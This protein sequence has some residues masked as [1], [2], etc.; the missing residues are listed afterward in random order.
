MFVLSPSIGI[1]NPDADIDPGFVDIKSTAVFTKDFKQRVP[2]TKVFVGL[3]GT[4]HP[5]KWSQ[6]WKRY[7]YGLRFCAID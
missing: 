4:G 7:V 5:A 2:S 6:L 1:G 3:A